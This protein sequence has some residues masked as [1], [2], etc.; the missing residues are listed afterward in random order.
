MAGY[1]KL[2]NS[3]L[4]STV[5]DLSVHVKIVWITMLALKDCRHHVL[6]SIPGLAKAAG[7]TREQC[8][9]ALDCFLS[10]DPDSRSKASEGRRLEE[11][12]G[13]WL[14]INGG[15][16]Q[17]LQGREDV[18][19][20]A[21]ERQAK[22]R[23]RNGKVTPRNAMSQNVTPVTT[24]SDLI[25][26]QL[27][28]TPDP[29]QTR[30]RR[31]ALV[32]P[33]IAVENPDPGRETVCPVDLARQA[34]ASGV[35][36]ELAEHLGAPIESL[37]QEAA[38]F[39]TYWVIGG[40]VGRRKTGWMRHLRQRI[41]LQHGSG[42]LRPLGSLTAAA[43]RREELAAPAVASPA[44]ETLEEREE[45]HK[46]RLRRAKAGEYGE[47]LAAACEG[48]APSRLHS[49]IDRIVNRRGKKP[50]PESAHATVTRMM[51]SR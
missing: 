3:I 28:S 22:H 21:A 5:W 18:L 7:V 23:A 43:H 44:H 34:E 50:G 19:A 38:D 29:D 32:P 12:D 31:A 11:I 27:I 46:N 20:R 49:A 24:P 37:R 1:T 51:G 10:P 40:G 39:Q 16:Y 41:V 4:L 42:M 25:S 14:L 8:E 13:G 48:L 2:F 17:E 33:A 15:K 30:A 36:A 9:E 47:K 35:L 45:A 6:A 26:S